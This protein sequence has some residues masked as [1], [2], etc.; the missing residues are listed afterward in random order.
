MSGKFCDSLFL[1]P[2]FCKLLLG[3]GGRHHLLIFPLAEHMAGKT[4]VHPTYALNVY[5]N[6]I[7]AEGN[8][9]ASPAMADVEMDVR[10]LQQGRLSVFTNLETGLNGQSIL[11]LQTF[12]QQ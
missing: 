12:T 7:V 1:C 11:L 4:F 10:I 9:N 8:G 2:K 3:I 5:A 6:G